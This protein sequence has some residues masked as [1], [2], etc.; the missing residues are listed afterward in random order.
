VSLAD[1]L[2]DIRRTPGTSCWVAILLPELQPEDRQTFLAAIDDPTIPATKLAEAL[3][4]LG[5]DIGAHSLQRHRRG[6]CR[7]GK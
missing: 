7:C 4:V 3:Q 5:H 6:L 1:L 2:S